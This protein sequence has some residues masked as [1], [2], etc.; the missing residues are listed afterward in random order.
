MNMHIWNENVADWDGCI[1]AHATWKAKFSAAVAKKQ[2]LDAGA[3]SRDDLCAVGRWLRSEARRKSGDEFCNRLLETHARFHRQ[4]M[5][6]ANEVN[7]GRFAEA[8][9]MLKAGAP[10]DMASQDLVATMLAVKKE[11]NER[12]TVYPVRFNIPVTWR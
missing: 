1:A 2:P 11:L 5:I 3:I 7:S 12:T 9:D 4:A 8:A 10:Y 6:V